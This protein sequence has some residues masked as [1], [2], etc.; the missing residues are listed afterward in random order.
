L[1]QFPYF[2]KLGGG[3]FLLIKCSLQELFSNEEQIAFAEIVEKEGP[4]V[5]AFL[6][7]LEI[8]I[9]IVKLLCLD[10]TNV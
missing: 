5:I 6:E 9:G 1:I 3:A 10:G 4:F 2:H 7:E 8:N